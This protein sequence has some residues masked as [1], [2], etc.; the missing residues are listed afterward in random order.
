MMLKTNLKKENNHFD[1]RNG[2][3]HVEELSI[4][5]LAKATKTPFYVYSAG[6]LED[7]LTSCDLHDSNYLGLIKAHSF[8]A[9]ELIH[10]KSWPSL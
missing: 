10:K 5:A 9:F 3:L 6:A 4:V 1:F 2:I 8:R 7:T